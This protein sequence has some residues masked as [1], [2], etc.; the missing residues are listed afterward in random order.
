MNKYVVFK[1]VDRG[2]PKEVGEVVA[3]SWKNAI[4]YYSS[5]EEGYFA[6]F[7]CVDSNDCK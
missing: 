6:V 4:R 2:H 5:I 7:I 1:M 3:S